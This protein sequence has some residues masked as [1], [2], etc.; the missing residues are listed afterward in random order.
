MNSRTWKAAL[1]L[2]FMTLAY[3]VSGW[4]A[5]CEH[6]VRSGDSLSGI[7][8]AKLGDSARWREIAELN[9]ISD[10]GRIA[11]GMKLALPCP[12]S[13]GS[14][15]TANRSM[16]PFDPDARLAW[17]EANP[18]Y[19][20]RACRIAGKRAIP[21]V[22][23]ATM[24]AEGDAFGCKGS[25]QAL[26]DL[27]R[28]AAPNSTACFLGRADACDNIVDA[29]KRHALSDGISY[30]GNRNKDSGQFE[31]TRLEV[32]IALPYLVGGYHFAKR[33]GR[34]EAGDAEVI[35]PWLKERVSSRTR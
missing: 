23:D 3:P 29:L 20:A 28:A 2:V 30:S 26:G 10:P 33:R 9:G 7:S 31:D 34:V 25:C 15:V 8:S 4:G 1:L 32:N 19:A 35:D 6:V 22:G 12:P 27:S 14:S 16:R 13:V 11:V 17:L 5:Q 24:P 18:R 21:I